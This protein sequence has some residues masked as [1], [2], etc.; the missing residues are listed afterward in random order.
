MKVIVNG[1]DLG[2]TMGINEGMVI[3]GERGILRS[4]TAIMNG[5]YIQEGAKM[6][7]EHP[8]IG[9]GL[10]LNLT[11][12]RPLTECPSLTDPQ[13]GLFYAGRTEVWKHNPDYTEI[14]KEWNAQMEE[15]I[16]VFEKLP[17]HID[18]HHSVHDATP[19]ALAISKQLAQKYNLPMR[20]Y[21][22]FQYVPDMFAKNSADDLIAIFKKYEGTDIEIMAHNAVVDLDLYRWSSYSFPRVQELDILCSEEM[23]NYVQEHNIEITNYSEAFHD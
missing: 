21:N 7:K 19:Q 1:D 5:A 23:K 20:R 16:H 14:E 8:E 4:T 9:V 15:F 12:G 13:T 3:G 11:L 6:M 22:S 2:Y 10:H 18:S 17:D